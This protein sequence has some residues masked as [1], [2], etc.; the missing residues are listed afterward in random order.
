M[1]LCLWLLL[2]TFSALTI[3]AFS[4]VAFLFFWCLSLPTRGTPRLYRNTDAPRLYKNTIF[5][6]QHAASLFV[7]GRDGACPVSLANIT[8]QRGNTIFQEMG[9]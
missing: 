7:N 8:K 9:L 5:W 3:N 2:G 4:L 1:D 6:R